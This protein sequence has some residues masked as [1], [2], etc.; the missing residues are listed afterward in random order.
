[1]LKQ[2]SNS[3]II[4]LYLLLFSQLASAIE[5][6]SIFDQNCKE[7][8]GYFVAENNN[9]YSFL[10]VNG[11]NITFN[12]ED[13]KGILIFNFVTPPLRKLSFANK[14]I[15]HLKTLT[16]L[17]DS[18]EDVFSGLPVQFIEDLVVFL[19]L[20]GGV[21][22]HKLD[23]IVRIRPYS[24]EALNKSFKNKGL[25]IQS[26]G[27]IQTCSKN[28]RRGRVR[29]N[30]ILI[31]K[32]K[33]QQFL[34][35]YKIGYDSLRSFQE[36]T[37][38]YARPILYAQKTRFGIQNQKIVEQS[39]FNNDLPFIEWSTGRPYRVQSL[40]SL[41]KIF[42]EFGADLDPILG[43]KTEIKA[44]FFHAIFTGNF[45][46]LSAGTSYLINSKDLSASGGQRISSH[47]VDSGLNYSALVGGDYGPHS[48]S[49]SLYY[50]VYIFGAED[51]VREILATSNSYGFRYMYTNKFFRFYVTTSLRDKDVANPNE[52]NIE[53]FSSGTEILPTSYSV[54]SFF[55]RS[56]VDYDIAEDTRLGVN[57][58]FHS[59]K[60]FE[61]PGSGTISL[62][63][64]GATAFAQKTFGDYVSFGVRGT[65]LID[66]VDGNLGGSTFDKTTSNLGFG[67]QGSIVF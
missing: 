54:N 62:A 20:N 31:D 25:D 39:G 49:V 41:G 50:P 61:Q 42:N 48:L 45:E 13:I 63:R 44:H 3:L 21:R 18:D 19:G 53:A 30:R 46:G 40:N 2:V 65:Y 24:G 28:G 58:I 9:K 51:E 38:V 59:M 34:S 66:A 60:Y 64:L 14:N 57:G 4:F 7:T 23:S 27:Y 35:N 22:V 32:I 37:Y 17:N 43:F 47:F 6:Y 8:T 67:F 26:K 12:R 52:D 16:V 11:R 33:I 1:M 29:P 56:G 10:T 55:V 15:D 36:R 5:F